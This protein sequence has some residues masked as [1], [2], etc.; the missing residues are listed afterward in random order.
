MGAG[1]IAESVR[2]FIN[3]IEYKARERVRKLPRPSITWYGN[4]GTLRIG[5]LL[6]ELGWYRGEP[7]IQ[8]GC[9]LLTVDPSIKM[10]TVIYLQ[11]S[12][13]ALCVSYDWA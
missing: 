13:L 1:K 8:A 5:G 9:Q 7:L 4:K 11:V 3:G 6:F 2:L 10:V 12:K